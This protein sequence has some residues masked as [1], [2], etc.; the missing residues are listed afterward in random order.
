MRDR[1]MEAEEADQQA[2]VSVEA[3]EE[4]EIGRDT[5]TV[6]YDT[7]KDHIVQHVQKTYKHGQDIAGSLRDLQKMDLQ[8]LQPARTQ[9]QE[10]DTVVK[11][12]E[13]TGMDIVFQAKLERWLECKDTLDQNLTKAYALIYSTYCNKTMQNRIEEHPGNKSVE[14]APGAP[15]IP[16]K[17][18]CLLWRRRVS[19]WQFSCIHRNPGRG[20]L[21]P[22]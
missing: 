15:G 1:N 19:P 13:Q 9:S 8:V 12:N 21:N 20:R 6:T 14:P 18:S 4:E 3:V 7:V 2:E 17:V 10:K 22:L 11:V 5:Q 16:G